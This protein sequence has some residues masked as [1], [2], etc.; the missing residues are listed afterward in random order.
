MWVLQPLRSPRSS[1]LLV[2]GHPVE[3]LLHER[4]TGPETAVAPDG[5][6][7]GDIHDRLVVDDNPHLQD[8]LEPRTQRADNEAM[9]VSLLS[10]G[11]RYEVQPASGA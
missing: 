4:L 2:E 10:K 8:D 1:L 11:G 3:E 7:T 6:R 5:R 9:D